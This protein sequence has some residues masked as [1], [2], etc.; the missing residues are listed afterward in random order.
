MHKPP[1]LISAL[2]SLALT[3]C[4][5]LENPADHVASVFKDPQTEIEVSLPVGWKA[6]ATSPRVTTFWGPPE[7]KA[8]VA[9]LHA[10]LGNTSLADDLKFV[11]DS[12]QRDYS[13]QL[14]GNETH[15]EVEPQYV[16]QTYTYQER[17][18][19]LD[20]IETVTVIH[21]TKHNR[22]IQLVQ[23]CPQTELSHCQGQFNVI[24]DSVFKALP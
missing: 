5:A 17:K 10:P 24:R 14:K 18:T 9:L 2:L 19:K 6:N 13:A 11:Q 15:A 3:S 16:Q 22:I 1:I 8:Y 7:T 12:V 21:D 20:M 4:V 23:G